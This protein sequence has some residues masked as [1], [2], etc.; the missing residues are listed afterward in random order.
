MYCTTLCCNVMHLRYKRSHYLK[1]L[2]QYI[3]STTSFNNI[4]SIHT[5][6]GVVG[7][8]EVSPS[9]QD[10]IP[11][12]GGQNGR[13]QCSNHAT[14]G[15]AL[16]PDHRRHPPELRERLHTVVSNMCTGLS[17]CVCGTREAVNGGFTWGG[18]WTV[19]L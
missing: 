18:L 12:A 16:R 6:D 2:W 13:H 14:V 19:M 15:R 17:V 10:S 11:E 4:Y 1:L 9:H 3:T 8:P 7:D 5:Y